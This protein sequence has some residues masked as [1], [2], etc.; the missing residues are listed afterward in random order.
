MSKRVKPSVD[1][2]SS[3]PSGAQEPAPSAAESA[4]R[5]EDVLVQFSVR[6]SHETR[7]RLFA[8]ST[9]RADGRRGDGATVAR[10]AL[11]AIFGD[12][13]VDEIRVVAV[14]QKTLKDQ[15]RVVVSEGLRALRDRGK[16]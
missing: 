12:G 14:D 10:A 8:A 9:T 1:P 6:L 3:A 16:T 7:D 13:L 4:T 11:D 5:P 2:V 15:I